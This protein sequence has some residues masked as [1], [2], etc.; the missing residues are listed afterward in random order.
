MTIRYMAWAICIFAV[1]QSATCAQALDA[2]E[3]LATQKEK[4]KAL[5]MMDGHWRGNAWIMTPS[6]QR[7][8]ITQTERIGPLLDGAVKVIEGRGYDSDGKTQFNAFGVIAYDL[9]Q[10]EL[11]MR[12]YAQGRMGDFVVQL[13]DDG[14]IWEIPAG[15]AAIRYTAKINDGKWL[16]YGE[17]I[18]PDREPVR[19]F[20]MNLQRLGDTDWPALQPVPRK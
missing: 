15:P 14:Y 3:A 10:Q 19:F 6:G 1:V 20:E 17:R 2:T 5:S 11:V 7:E 8:E 12:S 13:T 9:Q 16:E 4:L 18:V